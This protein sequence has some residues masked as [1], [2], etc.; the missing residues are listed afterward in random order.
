MN[1][2]KMDSKKIIKNKIQSVNKDI[3]N[4]AIV[5]SRCIYGEICSE[6]KLCGDCARDEYERDQYDE[7][8]K[9]FKIDCLIEM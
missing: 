3:T 1:S 2:K 7:E 4:K 6:K 8:Y 9:N 5:I